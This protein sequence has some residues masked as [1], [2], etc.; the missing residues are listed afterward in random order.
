VTYPY[1]GPQL[2]P[3]PQQP[4]GQPGMPVYPARPGMPPGMSPYAEWGSRFLG[5]LVDVGIPTAATF[6]VVV[7]IDLIVFALVASSGGSVV[8]AIVGGLLGLALIV[9]IAG[10]HI[11]NLAYRRGTTG[12]TLGQRVAKIRTVDEYTFQPI[13]FGRAF[14]RQL[15]HILDSCIIGIPIGWLAPLWEE[16][17]QTWADKIMHTVVLAADPAMPGM[18]GPA[19]PGMYGA[20]Q[21][22]YPQQMPGYP[23]PPGGYP[24]Q[25]P[26][27]V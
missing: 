22:G 20:P 27:S 26:Y 15:A 13:G 10:F 6:V 4:Y 5:Y 11:W 19:V 3:Q 23:Q 14:V 7:V 12:Q 21:P 2:G 25:P 17:R 1:P 8:V 9:A 16:K 18:P 24:Q